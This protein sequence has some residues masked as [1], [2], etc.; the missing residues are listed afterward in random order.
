MAIVTEPIIFSREI[1]GIN[2]DLII[3]EIF[4]KD[5]HFSTPE[6]FMLMIRVTGPDT[7]KVMDFFEDAEDEIFNI[8]TVEA[9]NNRE[10]NGK[11]ILTD[12]YVDEGPQLSVDID[13]EPEMVRVILDFIA[14]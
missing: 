7:G 13:I 1:N 3:P 6:H 5:L 9:K 10:I 12:S 8:E 11:F 4:V 2:A 14:K